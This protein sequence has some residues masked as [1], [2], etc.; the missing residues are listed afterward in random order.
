MRA[1][2]A[3][4]CASLVGIGLAR[5]AY[6]PLIPP[7]IEAHWFADDDVLFLS[8]AN[9]I[10]YLA[11]AL[12]GRP[13]ARRAG[14]RRTLQW[15]MALVA[16]CFFACAAP[17]S[18]PWFFCWRFLSGLAG[19]II[20][21]LAATSILPHVPPE[22]RGMA[23]GMIFLGVGL[24]IAGSGTVLPPLLALGL[25]QTWIGLGVMAAALT[26]LSWTWWP[27]PLPAAPG[28]PA[29][30]P[31][32][33][34]YRSA[35][36]LIYLQYALNAAGLVPMM[37]FLVDFIA[38]GLGWGAHDAA[39]FWIL[40]GVGAVFGPM[41]YG[42]MADRFGVR[43]TSVASL[44]GQLAAIAVLVASQHHLALAIATFVLGTFPPGIVPVY[45]G[46]IQH[47]VHGNPA[48]HSAAWSRSTVIFALVQALAGYGSSWLLSASGANHRL[49]FT[50]A[51]AALLLCM[52]V[53]LTTVRR[54]SATPN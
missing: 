45:L 1:V 15:M 40:Y 54:K 23:S 34:G 27:Q 28:T 32:P 7:L 39:L 21:V 16:L 8:A 18:V 50:I 26:A 47:A 46:K 24:G 43:F 20:M 6:T 48:A 38:R 29:P 52:L 51:G 5:F 37:V 36:R 2:L 9:L 3:G 30:A 41:L 10:G 13:L 42:G 17:V 11:G 33:N 53:E 49:L 4:L 14:S 22:R 31:A 35:L 12:A 25:A 19:G 44:L